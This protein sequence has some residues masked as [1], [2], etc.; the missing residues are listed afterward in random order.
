MTPCKTCPNRNNCQYQIVS[1]DLIKT[2]QDDINWRTDQLRKA[3]E[4]AIALTAILLVAIFYPV[5]FYLIKHV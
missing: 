4:I 3:R 2:M 1:K 5:V